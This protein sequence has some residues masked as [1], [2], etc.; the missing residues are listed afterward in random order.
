MSKNNQSFVPAHELEGIRERGIKRAERRVEEREHL[1][2]E[3]K[4]RKLIEEMQDAAFMLFTGVDIRD[5]IM[6]ENGRPAII[7]LTRDRIAG[8]KAAADISD[9]LLK[10]VLP[11][12]K[13]IELQDGGQ[14][15]EGR[16]LENIELSN[17][18]R[19]YM[20]AI[21]KRGTVTRNVEF[22][23]GELVDDSDEMDFLK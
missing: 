20:E 7:P 16:I 6:D 15:G 17:R 11:D 8:L 13:Q 19:I 12:L 4:S 3:I 18:M 1:R 5:D 2:L 10:K 22:V 23:E 9:K 21:G 14:Q